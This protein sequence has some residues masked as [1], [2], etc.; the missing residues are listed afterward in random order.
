MR[1]A[2]VVLGFIVGSAAAITFALL[3]STVVFL[4][5]QSEYPRVRD[6]LVP[7]LRSAGLFSLLTIAAGST[8]YSEIKQ[9][10][11]RRAAWLVLLVVLAVVALYHAWPSLTAA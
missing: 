3:G 6:E 11:W 9:R 1:P 5:L 7:L 4:V 10:A 8:F 2:V